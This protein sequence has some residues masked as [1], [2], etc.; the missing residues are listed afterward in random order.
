MKYKKAKIEVEYL[1]DKIVKDFETRFSYLVLEDF[2]EGGYEDITEDEFFYEEY[3]MK[4]HYRIVEL[5]LELEDNMA[6]KFMELKIRLIKLKRIIDT[7]ISHLL[8]KKESAKPSRIK[9]PKPQFII[10][11]NIESNN[12]IKALYDSLKS[13]KL[14]NVNEEE[15]NLHFGNKWENK[16]QWFG[17]QLQITCLVSKLIERNFLHIETSNYKYKLIVSHFYNK[18]GKPFKAK[19]LGSIW[20]DKKEMLPIDDKIVNI[21]EEIST[22]N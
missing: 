14:I 9:Q 5:L 10:N 2:Y 11:S 21:I 1:E 3:F 6:E 22:H 20:S 4:Y 16:I 15:F 12:F 18:S 8:Q 19:Q 13:K 17:T 7:K